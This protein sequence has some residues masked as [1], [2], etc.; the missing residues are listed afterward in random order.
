MSG[1]RGTEKRRQTAIIQCRVEPAD[2]TTIEARAKAAGMSVSQIVRAALLG[3]RPPR[4]KV[5]KEAIGRLRADLASVR[6]ELGKS[7]SNL[8]QI[9][10]HLNAG[11]PGDIG[12]GALDA[13]LAEHEQAI[14][15]L[16][17][18]RLAILQSLGFERDRK[19]PKK[20]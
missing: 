4:P 13:A 10:Y 11:R 14:R 6:A 5:D 1:Q 16:E 7:G 12:Y 15:T 9:A 19:P 18:L 8:N 20:G 2:K 17:E 3:Y